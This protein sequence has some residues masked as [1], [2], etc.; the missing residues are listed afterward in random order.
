MGLKFMKKKQAAK[1]TASATLSDAQTTM[2][3][4]GNVEI[5][6]KNFTMTTNQSSKLGKKESAEVSETWTCWGCGHS[7]TGEICS[8]CGKKKTR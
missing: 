6:A 3:K 5:K 4:D 2:D 7:N 1:Q 8:V